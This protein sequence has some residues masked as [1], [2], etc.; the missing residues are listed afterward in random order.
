ME[1]RALLVGTLAVLVAPVILEA[2]QADKVARI[3]VLSFGAP[4]PFREG[5]KR[6]LFDLG[7]VEGRNIVIEYRWADG[8]GI[9]LLGRPASESGCYV[10][11][12][13]PGAGQPRPEAVHVAFALGAKAT[14][15]PS[16]GGRPSV[17]PATVT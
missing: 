12:R 7:Y 2:Q 16:G 17:S 9:G 13:E 10:A 5:F 4:E 6:A 3:G 8:C 1:R 15:A 11:V 14:S